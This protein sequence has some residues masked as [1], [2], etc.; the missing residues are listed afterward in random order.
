MRNILRVREGHDAAKVGFVELFFDLVFVFAITQLSHGLLHHLSLH[1]ALESLLLFVAVWWAWVFTTWVTNWV[2]PDKMPVRIMLFALMLL[3][4]VLSAAIPTAFE[5]RGLVFA[6]AY[7]GMQLGRS[8]FM[9]WALHKHHPVNQRNFTRISIWF[10]VSGALW[11]A[12]GL[13]APELRFPLWLAALGLELAGPA[14]G[15]YVPKLG[16]TPTTEWDVSGDHIAERCGLF[17]IIALG[18][19]IMM[20]G[21]T[22]A[23]LEW[24]WQVVLAFASGTLAAIGMW[25]IYF[26]V[27]AERAT[28]LIAHSDDPGRLARFAYTYLHIPLVAGI[29]LSAVGTEL[30]LK[31]PSG[32][33][34]PATIISVLGAALL[35]LVGN[36]LFKRATANTCP[37][38]HFVGIG[39]LALLA[40]ASPTLSPLIL[41]LLASA[42]LMGV[43]A[44]ETVLHR[45]P[46]P[47]A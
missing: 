25:W 34:D 43:A 37:V 41:S 31:H 20:A 38:S 18:E 44:S 33:A 17:V 42:T 7:V 46:G 30:V 11:L 4:L 29:V 28:H 45:L 1:G 9:V 26:N 47:T 36:I 35:Y 14:A 6:L 12:G 19:I 40:L 32:H 23:D 24:A 16:R 22:F 21:A 10:A 15:F 8:L 13:L 2:S 27:G 3:G 39:V 5:E